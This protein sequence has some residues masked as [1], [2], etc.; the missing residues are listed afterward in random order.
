[1]STRSLVFLVVVSLSMIL[2]TAYFFWRIGEIDKMEKC[3]SGNDGSEEAALVLGS[4]SHPDNKARR[5]KCK[6]K[7]DSAKYLLYVAVVVTLYWVGDLML[8]LGVRKSIAFLL[9]MGLVALFITITVSMVRIAGATACFGKDWTWTQAPPSNTHECVEGM[10]ALR[11][12]NKGIKTATKRKTQMGKVALGWFI[13]LCIALTLILGYVLYKAGYTLR[14]LACP[15]KEE[16]LLRKAYR[17]VK[18][19]EEEEE[20]G[21]G[22]RRDADDDQDGIPMRDMRG[23]DRQ[24]VLEWVQGVPVAGGYGD[25]DTHTITEGAPAVE[26]DAPVASSGADATFSATDMMSEGRNT[27][28]TSTP[29]P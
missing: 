11:T 27:P 18:G 22:E 19:E 12:Y 25:V 7:N 2:G 21:G 1:M 9:G 13:T 15:T 23:M 5:Q 17:R 26:K 8:R 10:G 24:G 4:C 6:D 16:L 28:S 20:E 3:C 29:D 14:W